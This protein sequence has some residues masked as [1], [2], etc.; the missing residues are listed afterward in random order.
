MARRGAFNVEAQADDQLPMVNIVR[1]KNAI[2]E[3]IEGMVE[4]LANRP[5]AHAVKGSTV[6]DTFPDKLVRG[7]A[8]VVKFFSPDPEDLAGG[9]PV[10]GAAPAVGVIT[11]PMSRF[12]QAAMKYGP[13]RKQLEYLDKSPIRYQFSNE[14]IPGA[15]GRVRTSHTPGADLDVA[16]DN[17]SVKFLED[18]SRAGLMRRKENKIF[19]RTA[20]AH[21][22]N[23]AL[24]VSQQYER[25]Y[26]EALASGM[27]PRRAAATARAKALDFSDPGSAS[28][29]KQG[30]K[31]RENF[32]NAIDP[33]LGGAT[34]VTHPKRTSAFT[35]MYQRFLTD[36]RR[37]AYEKGANMPASGDAL[38]QILKDART[39]AVGEGHTQR[40]AENVTRMMMR[41]AGYPNALPKKMVGESEVDDELAGLLRRARKP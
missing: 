40:S 13:L 32:E 35:D 33:D 28:L 31:A 23:H 36:M 25:A 20:P 15:W 9:F 19:E 37:D 3:A 21:E 12:V 22:I 38:R 17:A 30:G 5:A 39:Q 6:A 8:N 2:D 7:A 1:S 27:D 4:K 41:Q 11:N 29:L 16:V 34:A 26:G 24:G 10:P 14:R 18:P